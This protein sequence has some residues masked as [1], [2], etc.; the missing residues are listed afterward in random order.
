VRA[1]ILD[2]RAVSATILDGVR[3]EVGEFVA[4]HGRVPVLATVLVGDDPASHTY[5]RMKAHR[6]A[7]VGMESHRI[8]LDADITTAEL[9]GRVRELSDDPAVD[10]ILLQ[11]PVPRQ[12]D[13][14]AA[15]EAITPGKDVDGVTR[16]SFATMAFGEGGF[17]SVTPGGIMAHMPATRVMSD[18]PP[19]P[20]ARPSSRRCPAG[21]GP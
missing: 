15:F 16:T 20:S 7:K 9:V 4:E 6:C 5:V 12:I 1:Q 10:G 8:E 18:S 3:K 19:R 2:G 17:D 21:S 14:R 13:E 11:H